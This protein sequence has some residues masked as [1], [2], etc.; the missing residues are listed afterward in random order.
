MAVEK[1]RT[2]LDGNGFEVRIGEDNFVEATSGGIPFEGGGDIFGELGSD[3][4][5][6]AKKLLQDFVSADFGAIWFAEAE[7]FTDFLI[8][9]ISDAE[10]TVGSHA[11][12][13][14]RVDGIGIVEAGEKELKKIFTNRGDGP[15]RRKI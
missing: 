2:A 15:F 11:A 13:I 6:G 7:T 1:V 4:R 9:S 10:N 14:A 3:K 12:E 5:N 8:E